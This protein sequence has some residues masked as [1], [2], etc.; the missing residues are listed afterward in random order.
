MANYQGKW[1]K[2][3][4]AKEAGRM[5]GFKKFYDDLDKLSMIRLM[6]TE[7]ETLIKTE[8]GEVLNYPEYTWLSFLL[9]KMTMKIK[10]L[11]LIKKNLY[12]RLKGNEVMQTY[13]DF[14]LNTFY[15]YKYSD[16]NIIFQ[17]SS[18]LSV[19]DM[20]ESFV[21]LIHNLSIE[22][23]IFSFV[24]LRKPNLKLF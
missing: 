22:E 16:L 21:K 9:Y 19:V 5:I 6:I 11:L 17:L 18:Q 10:V 4:R 8:N 3:I 15:E 7:D 24:S 1:S 14:Y 12:D 20:Y 23:S 2:E 13:L